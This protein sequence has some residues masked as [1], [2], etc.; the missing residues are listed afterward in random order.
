[1]GG[2]NVTFINRP[3]PSN[4]YVVMLRPG[5][6]GLFGLLGV[7]AGTLT[8]IFYND[9]FYGMLEKVWEEKNT[10]YQAQAKVF[11]TFNPSAASF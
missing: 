8:L 6:A 5:L 3:P 1:M 4:G 9:I 7:V 11:R 2:G 10:N